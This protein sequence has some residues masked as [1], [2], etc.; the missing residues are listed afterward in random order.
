MMES[1]TEKRQ[2]EFGRQLQKHNLVCTGRKGI[3]LLS[4][5]LSLS[6]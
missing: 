4:L 5:S 6:L 1:D 3:L 2:L